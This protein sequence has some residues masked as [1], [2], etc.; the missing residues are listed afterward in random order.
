MQLIER[1][2]QQNQRPKQENR[3]KK[4][5]RENQTNHKTFQREFLLDNSDKN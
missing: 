3:N 5:Q 1:L 2:R 4:P